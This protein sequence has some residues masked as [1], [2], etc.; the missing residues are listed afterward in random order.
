M[1]GRVVVNV[2]FFLLR[3][4]FKQPCRPRFLFSEP[5]E[6]EE[7]V[8]W[9]ATVGGDMSLGSFRS[10]CNSLFRGTPLMGDAVDRPRGL[11]S[12]FGASLHKAKAGAE[13]SKLKTHQPNTSQPG[14]YPAL[15]LPVCRSAMAREHA[16]LRSCVQ[17]H[18][19]HTP[20][21]FGV[22]HTLTDSPQFQNYYFC[23]TSYADA[24]L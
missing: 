20:L 10:L 5:S 7:G 19:V 24:K 1:A 4:Q 8:S 17:L 21:K 23:L 16:L 18:S 15:S 2:H 11:A 12:R 14:L 13:T 3:R 22:V 9:L 6:L